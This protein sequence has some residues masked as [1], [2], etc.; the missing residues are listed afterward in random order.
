MSIVIQIFRIME[1]YQDEH[2][3]KVPQ[4]SVEEFNKRVEEMKKAKA[5]Q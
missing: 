4:R 5:S 3:K 2:Y 1:K